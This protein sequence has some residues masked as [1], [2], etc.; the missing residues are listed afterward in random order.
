MRMRK[1]GKGQSVVFCVPQEMNTK[2]LALKAD[3]GDS[4]IDV[5]D[6]LCWVVSETFN[7][8]RRSMPL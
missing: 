1:L 8:I 4:N 5:Y 2:I 3:A 6:I 7:D